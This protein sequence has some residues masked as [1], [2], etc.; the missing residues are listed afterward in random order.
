[1]RPDTGT[2][3]RKMK[4]AEM[5]IRSEKIKSTRAGALERRVVRETYTPETVGRAIH[6]NSR[7]GRSS[8]RLRW[9]WLNEDAHGVGWYGE[10]WGDPKYGQM[11]RRA[12][13][14]T[15]CKA[16]AAMFGSDALAVEPER[17][18]KGWMTGNIVVTRTETLDWGA[19]A[20]WFSIAR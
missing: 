18:A 17:D 16:M 6:D 4:G 8:K 2:E 19:L 11:R 3:N 14:A 15:A 1:M 12:S 7:I 13:T 10:F 5:K 9:A 20:G